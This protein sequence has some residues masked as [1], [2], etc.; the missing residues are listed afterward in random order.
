MHTDATRAIIEI[1][2]DDRVHFL[3]GLTTQ[4][5]THLRPERGLFAALLT[6][7]GKI[8]HDF[9]L[10]QYGDAILLDCDATQKEA[11]LKR[12]SM[13][14]LRAKVTLRDATAENCADHQRTGLEKADHKRLPAGIF[15]RELLRC[16][17]GIMRLL[18]LRHGDLKIKTSLAE[19]VHPAWRGRGKN[20]RPRTHASFPRIPA[21]SSARMTASRWSVVR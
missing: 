5:I 19:Q 8:L 17:R 2:G 1:T 3:Q 10:L 14:K 18:D 21:T 11:L 7:Q 16:Q 13:Y 4:D 6:P 12:L 20:Q 15:H 9:F